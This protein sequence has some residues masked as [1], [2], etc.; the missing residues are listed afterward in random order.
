[1]SAPAKLQVDWTKVF[2][3]KPYPQQERFVFGSARRRQLFLGGRGTGKT[4]ALMLKVLFLALRNHGRVGAVFGRTQKEIEL[5]LLRYFLEH[6]ATFQRVTGIRLVRS[7]NAKFGVTTLFNGSQIFWLTYG[8]EDALAN[9]RGYDLAWAVMDEVDHAHVEGVYAMGVIDFAVRGDHPELQLAVATTPDGLRGVTGHFLQLQRDR[10][11][12]VFVSH[13]TVYD[14]PFKSEREI[15]ILKAGCSNALWKQEGLGYVLTPSNVV[16][17]EY[18]EARHVVPW[19][20][21]RDLPYV[22]CIDWGTSHAYWCMV[23]V[24]PDGRWIVAREQKVEGVSRIQ[25]RELV[26]AAVEDIG[27][28]PSGVANDRAVRSEKLWARGYFGSVAEF[29]V[30]SCD[31]TQEQSIPFGVEAIRSMMDPVDEEPKLLFSDT[32]SPT[33]RKDGRG[34]RGALINYRFAMRMDPDGSKVQTNQPLK[35]DINDHPIDALRYGVVMFA[36]QRKL[37]GGRILPFAR[38]HPERYDE[39]TNGEKARRA[40]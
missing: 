8:R 13:A 17:G 27:Y 12:N 22:L 9:A 34:L 40:A 25:F 36:K 16:F 30:K 1:M 19:R 33:L 2:W 18:D 4:W 7:H 21:K 15:E 5:K 20:W 23:Q 32:L 31:S 6:C 29:G 39:A 35:D 3:A 24:T 14:N 38:A 28:P 11:P 26:K 37:H 10:D